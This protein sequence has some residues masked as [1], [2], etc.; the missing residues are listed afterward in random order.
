LCEYGIMYEGVMRVIFKSIL[1]GMVFLTPN[2]LCAETADSKIAINFDEKIEQQFIDDFGIREKNIIEDMVRKEIAKTFGQSDYKFEIQFK[3][4]APN[5]P[6]M[7]QMNN[8]SGLSM[9]SFS[10]G[11]ADLIGKLYDTNGNNISTIN[12]DYYSTNVYE[13]QYRWT[14]DDAEYS[15]E[16]LITKMAKSVKK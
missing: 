9:Q 4:I 3:Q 1:F 16:R 10:V 12:Y 11:G 13:S 15:I 8:K 7:E 5:R 14:W 2:L 6:T